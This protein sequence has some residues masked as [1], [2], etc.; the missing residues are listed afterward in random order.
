MKETDYL[1]IG[2]GIAGL[3][4]AEEIR[5]ND[6]NC[7]ITMISKEKYLTY[8]RPK[9][10]HNLV[11]EF[12]LE[13][14]FVK[15]PEWYDANEIE[16]LLGTEV[17]KFDFDNN[18][19]RTISEDI[20]YKTIILTIGSYPFIPPIEG[21]E[22]E[23][24]FTLRNYED[25]LKIK[26]YMNDKSEISVIGGGL[27]GLE[28]AWALKKAGKDVR[29]IEC[30]ECLLVNQLDLESS[31]YLQDYLLNE[32]FKTSIFSDIDEIFGEN[33]VQGISVGGKRFSSD[34]VL[35]S[36]G[37]R[38]SV[39]QLNETGL[40]INRGLI[41][42]KNMKTNIDN[43]YA[44]GDISEFDN[45]ICGLWTIASDQGKCVGKNAVGIKSDYTF[46]DPFTIINLGKI[47]IFSMGNVKNYDEVFENKSLNKNA[48]LF[49]KDKRI[50]GGIL[51]NNVKLINKLKSIIGKKYNYALDVSSNFE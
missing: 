8:F 45:K 29:I 18:L 25:L 31:S 1:I 9:L 14:I 49:L 22:M 40:N 28:A 43:V 15:K 32:G 35:V 23:G 38:P 30:A 12:N 21:K 24:V 3:S 33:R 20:G 27:L 19:V 44:A 10:S 34:V 6:K 11:S 37:V 39:A 47:N 46:P 5:K 26:N 2:N 7:D 36:T 41:V 4:A 50:T 48:K 17:T 51:I 16:L 42:N 13:S